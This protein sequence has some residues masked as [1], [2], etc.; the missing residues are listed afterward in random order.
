MYSF[1]KGLSLLERPWRRVSLSRGSSPALV[2]WLTFEFI[3]ELEE[4]APMASR[5]LSSKPKR[6]LRSRQR[7]GT[8]NIGKNL[9]HETGR[10]STLCNL[11]HDHD[12]HHH[13]Y[14]QDFYHNLDHMV[15]LVIINHHKH[16]NY[17]NFSAT[18]LPQAL[19]RSTS[20]RSQ[21]WV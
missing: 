7:A 18:C 1:L 14:L 9:T 10:A 2:G 20:T 12:N 16:K 4:F 11:V 13:N 6:S 5:I 15:G 21:T 19:A 17:H 3:K 8:L